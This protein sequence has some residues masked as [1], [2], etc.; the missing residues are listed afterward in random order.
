MMERSPPPF[1]VFSQAESD[2]IPVDALRAL[3]TG[4]TI[5]SESAQTASVTILVQ[6]RTATIR[7]TSRGADAHDIHAARDAERRGNA[8]G[9]GELAARCRRVFIVEPQDAPESLVWELCAA[10][11]FAGLGP[12]LPPDAS[13]LYGVNG[14]RALAERLRGRAQ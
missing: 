6:E 2:R 8:A 11:A 10:L 12:I 1:L 5:H 13:T 14:A 9:M 7:I 4:V 3:G